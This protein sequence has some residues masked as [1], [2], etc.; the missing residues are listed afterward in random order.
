MIFPDM[1][2]LRTGHHKQHVDAAAHVADAHGPVHRVALTRINFRIPVV[3][4]GEWAGE[5]LLLCP[6]VVIK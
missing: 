5:V 1:A 4:Q 2:M 6:S 3:T